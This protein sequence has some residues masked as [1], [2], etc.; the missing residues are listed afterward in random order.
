MLRH[1]HENIKDDVI[2]EELYAS[3]EY[4]KPDFL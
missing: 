2:V 3:I 4:K 1:L